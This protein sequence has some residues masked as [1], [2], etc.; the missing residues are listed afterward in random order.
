MASSGTGGD[1]VGGGWT[2]DRPDERRSARPAGRPSG[3]DLDGPE[4]SGRTPGGARWIQHARDAQRREASIRCRAARGGHSGRIAP[5]QSKGSRDDRA[6]SPD[7]RHS[8]TP[9][10]RGSRS[11]TGPPSG[12]G[13]RRLRYFRLTATIPQ[14]GSMPQRTTAEA[15]SCEPFGP[16]S[17]AAGRS[18]RDRLRIRSP[19]PMA[20]T[21]PTTRPVLGRSVRS[22]LSTAELYEDDP[23]RGGPRR[24]RWPTRRPDRQAHRSLAGGQVH[25]RRARQPR[26]DLVGSGQPADLGGRLR[27]TTVAPD[28]LPRRPR[29][30]QPGLLHRRGR[31][32]SPVAARLH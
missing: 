28:R 11:W 15:D 29:P 10:R 14:R 21:A 18:D 26:Q 24:G 20:S 30:V 1:A 27:S 22:N 13:T 4:R 7:I 19:S 16:A 25:R 31:R 5:A 2:C 6:R 12:G 8:R 3:D 32:P 9:G 17:R 23:P